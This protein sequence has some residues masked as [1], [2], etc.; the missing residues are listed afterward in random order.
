MP[1][2]MTVLGVAMRGELV[3]CDMMPPSDRGDNGRHHM[4]R[5]VLVA[6]A[7]FALTFSASGQSE[8][9]TIEQI[10]RP[11]GRV[12]FVFKPTT[13]NMQCPAIDARATTPQLAPR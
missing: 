1:R 12:I 13:N 6:S 10:T 8:E 5:L 4:R 11:G 7:I 9:M 3:R 2:R